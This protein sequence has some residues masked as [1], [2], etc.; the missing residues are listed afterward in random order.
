MKRIVNTSSVTRLAAAVMTGLAVLCC[1]KQAGGPSDPSG[2]VPRRAVVFTAGLSGAGREEATKTAAVSSLSAFRVSATQGA[3]GSESSAWNDVA[4]GL[5][6]GLYVGNRFW[7]EDMDPVYHFY[8]SNAAL[9]FSPS[10]CTVTVTDA[11]DVVCAY[12]PTSVYMSTN[13]LVFDHVFARLGGVT[14]TAAA[15][16]TVSDVEM[17]F[18]PVTGGTYNL[19]TGSGRTDGTGWSAPVAGGRTVVSNATA[20]TKVN[21]IY[22]V[23]GDYTF[24]CEWTATEDDYTKS[25]SKDVVVSM[26]AGKVN[27][28]SFTLGG[29][30]T[31]LTFG[32]ELGDWT[33]TNVDAGTF[34]I[35]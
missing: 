19:R 22:L 16:Y 35:D 8:A 14:V 3:T 10:G 31:Q 28:L 1:T 18:T 9:S 12:L 34:P 13:A 4:F 29:D 2:V 6:H 17:S 20:G 5:D 30:V 27:A 24:H 7:P 26:V 33:E 21:D 15:G 23:P 32:V 25:F 11:T